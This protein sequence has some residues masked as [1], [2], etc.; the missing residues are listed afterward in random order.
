MLIAHAERYIS[1]RQA[2]G[3]KLHDLSSNLVAYA[4]FATDRGDTHI[5]VASPHCPILRSGTPRVDDIN[6]AVPE[7]FIGRRYPLNYVSQSRGS[8]RS[9]RTPQIC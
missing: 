5:R 8:L 1:L 3:Y 6:P 9:L 7:F 2:P 4:R